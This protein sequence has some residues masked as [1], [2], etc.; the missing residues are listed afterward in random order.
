MKD[1]DKTKEQLITELM[2]LRH[3]I[4]ELEV[5]GNQH[6]QAQEQLRVSAEYSVG[7]HRA[8]YIKQRIRSLL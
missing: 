8:H 6:Y 2:E 7:Q 4:T 5:S 3:R 1:E